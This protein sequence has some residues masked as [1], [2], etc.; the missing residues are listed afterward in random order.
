[1]LRIETRTETAQE[2]TYALAGQVSRE[3]LPELSELLAAARGAGLRVT[4]DL[5]GVILVDRDFVRFLAA[6]EGAGVELANCPAYV[7]SWL[8]CEGGR[9]KTP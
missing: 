3:H 4:L 6:G 8:L 1:M 9:E 7:L 5:A 2:V